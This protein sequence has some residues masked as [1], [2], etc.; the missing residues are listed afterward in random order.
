M[1][2]AGHT[3]VRAREGKGPRRRWRCL[4]M[5]PSLS[6]RIERAGELLTPASAPSARP[7][8]ARQ[9]ERR[10]GSACVR[11]SL[12]HALHLSPFPTRRTLAR[13]FSPASSPTH[14]TTPLRPHVQAHLRP[15][16]GRRRRR[17]QLDDQDGRRD[18]EAGRGKRR[19]RGVAAGFGRGPVLRAPRPSRGTPRREGRARA[20]RGCACAWHRRSRRPASP[21]LSRSHH[22]PLHFHHPSIPSLQTEELLIKRRSLLEKKI[23]QELEKAKEQTQLKN[24]RGETGER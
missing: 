7:C 11:A 10:P 1:T 5:P 24:K 15:G 21:T 13:S 3:Q 2:S 14:H 19:E 12:S 16:L 17:R 22:Q 18:P 6:A 23:V 9:A 4:S 20:G 8:V